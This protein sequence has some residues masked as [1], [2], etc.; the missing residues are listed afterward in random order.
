[1]KP[2]D[3]L[4]A[5][6]RDLGA[7]LGPEGF[8][9]AATGA[10]HSCG[11]EFASGEYRRGDRRL[12]M[13]FRVSLGLVVYHVGDAKIGHE[14][15]LRAVRALDH[16]DEGGAY[17]GFHEEPAAQFAALREDLQVFGNRFLRGSVEQF[18]DLQHWLGSNPRPTGFAALFR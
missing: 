14:E 2:V 15:Y 4:A 3:V 16:I 9:F 13:S 18:R 5:G 1:V 8:T 10:G 7:I 17:P 6:A 12:E 11:G